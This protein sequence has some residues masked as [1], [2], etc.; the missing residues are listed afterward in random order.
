MVD[1]G[2]TGIRW[3][4]E[5]GLPAMTVEVPEGTRSEMIAAAVR[6]AEQESGGVVLHIDTIFMPDAVL[7]YNY[8]SEGNR[9]NL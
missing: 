1:V 3:T 5:D 7:D 2:M 9:G 4:S 8:R 6:A